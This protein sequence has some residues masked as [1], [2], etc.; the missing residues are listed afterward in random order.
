MDTFRLTNDYAE[1]LMYVHVYVSFS[2][3]DTLQIFRVFS[4]EWEQEAMNSLIVVICYTKLRV[5][6]FISQTGQVLS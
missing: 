1:F 3:S 4:R 5:M 2:E 6:Y